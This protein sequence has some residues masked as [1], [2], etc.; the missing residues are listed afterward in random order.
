MKKFRVKFVHAFAI[1]VSTLCGCTLAESKSNASAHLYYVPHVNA[2]ATAY[3]GDDIVSR[4]VVVE[5]TVEDFL[6][7]AHAAT[8]Q[9][10]SL[11]YLGH[12]GNTISIGYRESHLSTMNEDKRRPDNGTALQFDVSKTH[13]IRCKGA[14]I[15]I[16]DVS[17]NQI[18]Y[19]VLKD[20]D[21]GL[22]I[23]RA[24]EKTI[25]LNS[26]FDPIGQA[27]SK[28]HHALPLPPALVSDLS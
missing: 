22:G 8:I 27:S 11:I 2:I 16:I 9:D 10:R 19:R 20:L 18:R 15:E 4:I 14:E 17:D 3:V 6:G 7:A 13:V 21:G 12:T 25:S 5:A 23:N 1:L 28:N 24:I 26:L